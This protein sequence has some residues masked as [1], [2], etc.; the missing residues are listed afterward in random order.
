VHKLFGKPNEQNFAGKNDLKKLKN[1]RRGRRAYRQKS[2]EQKAERVNKIQETRCLES[3]VQQEERR[4]RDREQTAA[5]LERL[6]GEQ[7]AERREKN[8]KQ[9]AAARD[10][11]GDKQK[12]EITEKNFR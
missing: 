11:L 2:D 5:A 12:E 6:I 7:R 10:R 8:R 4:E 3:E 9:T 1:K